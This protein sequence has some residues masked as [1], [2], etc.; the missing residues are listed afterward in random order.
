MLPVQRIMSTS[1]NREAVRDF[2]IRPYW[3]SRED[4]GHVPPI[5]RITYNL[6]GGMRTGQNLGFL[7]IAI[8]RPG[9]A[10]APGGSRRRPCRARSA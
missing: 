10:G 1:K 2:R 8:Y 7:L 3:V 9:E 6:A 5:C 4:A